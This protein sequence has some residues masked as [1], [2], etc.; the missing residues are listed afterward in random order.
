V[1]SKSPPFSECDTPRR[2]IPFALKFVHLGQGTT[3][4][5]TS[6]IRG[7]MKKSLNQAGIAITDTNPPSLA[8]IDNFRNQPRC[9]EY[10]C[11]DLGFAKQICAYL[12][13]ALIAHAK[14]GP[15]CAVENMVPVGALLLLYMYLNLVVEITHPHSLTPV[16]P[17]L[18]LLQPGQ[19]R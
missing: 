1:V 16:L 3:R 17:V 14:G 10:C 5:T 4:Q 15:G 19:G 7:A 9:C 11:E 2:A 6:T 13:G 8:W 12:I 18:R